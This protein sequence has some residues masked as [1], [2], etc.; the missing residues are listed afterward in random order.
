VTAIGNCVLLVI[1]VGCF[2]CWAVALA[3]MLLAARSRRPG[4]PR[5]T[6]WEGPFDVMY[7]PSL[8]T[9]EG[10]RHRR[11]CLAGIAGFLLLGALG[12]LGG[13][14]GTFPPP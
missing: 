2:A 13:L 8:L 6:L 1:G 3:S 9:E 11:R 4:A 10:K 12:T 7:R 14:L 5:P